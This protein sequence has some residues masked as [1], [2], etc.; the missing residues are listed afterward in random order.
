MLNMFNKCESLESLYL[1][2]FDMLSVRSIRSMFS[3]CKSLISLDLKNFNTLNIKNYTN[4]FKETNPNLIYCIN[5]TI[6]SDVIISQLDGFI[7]N[8][9]YFC[10]EQ[11]KKM[12]NDTKECINNVLMI[13]F[14]NMNI[15]IYAINLV[16][17][18]LILNL[19]I[20]IYVKILYVHI[21]IIMI[22][23]NVLII[24][25]KDII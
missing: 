21:I 1:N 10:F 20:H 24:F 15:I 23:Q 14:I 7:N 17:V 5:E 13:I 16:Q 22:K 3:N 19:I 12:I 9:S 18:K 25:Q 4:I 6:T 11:L 2:N 8:C